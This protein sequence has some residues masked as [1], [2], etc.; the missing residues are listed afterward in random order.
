MAQVGFRLGLLSTCYLGSNGWYIAYPREGGLFYNTDEVQLIDYLVLP[1]APDNLDVW[2]EAVNT[3]TGY[4][5]EIL[6][7]HF[8]SAPASSQCCW[9]AGNNP[10]CSL[11]REASF[12]AV[13][14]IY[15]IRVCN[16]HYGPCTD[17]KRFTF[18]DPSKRA[19]ISLIAGYWI[20]PTE[21]R[22]LATGENLHVDWSETYKNLLLFF[23]NSDNALVG[24]ISLSETSPSGYTDIA[25][26]G[27]QTLTAALF[28]TNVS[29]PLD[30]QI[31]YIPA[32]ACTEDDTRCSGY[33]LQRCVGN[34]WVTVETNSASCGYVPDCTCDSWMPG[35]CISD[36]HRRMTRTCIPTGCAAEVLDVPD[37]SCAVEPEPSILPLIVLGGCALLGAVMLVKK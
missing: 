31:Y 2:V 10:C 14:G 4:S 26:S 1:Y 5:K 16:N 28:S 3:H 20:S 23:Y 34:A 12:F 15:D 33:D 17:Y 22:I 11:G 36:T 24:G 19:I 6:H 27:D 21:Y 32:Y 7:A 13:N 9:F 18:G 29:M 30:S 37:S 35:E 25:I 8:D